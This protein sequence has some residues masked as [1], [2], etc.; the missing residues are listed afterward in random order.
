MLWKH[1]NGSPIYKAINQTFIYQFWK[2]PSAQMQL[3]WLCE[4]N[5]Q[6]KYFKTYK[7]KFRSRIN[8]WHILLWFLKHLSHKSI[9]TLW[10]SV[11]IMFHMFKI[12]CEYI[13]LN[14]N[15]VPALQHLQE[16]HVCLSLRSSNDVHAYLI[17]LKNKKYVWV[18]HIL[19]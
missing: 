14:L 18:F 12:K 15:M 8:K 1:I 7:R 2:I 4:N 9:W 3:I 11:F 13:Y 5:V 17:K 19:C 16:V 6:A 10:I